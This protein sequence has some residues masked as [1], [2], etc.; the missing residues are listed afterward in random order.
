MILKPNEKLDVVELL[1]DLDKYEPRRREW[2]WRERA[3]DQH[4]GQFEYHEISKS[5][6]NYVPLPP[7]KFL[8]NIDPQPMQTITTEI[9][10]GRFEDD[11]R[12]MRMAAWH[13]A[14]H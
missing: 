13:G 6:K 10:S 1:K 11:I 4:L 7:A 12:R 8:E 2:V 3:E 14:D 5:L 9:A